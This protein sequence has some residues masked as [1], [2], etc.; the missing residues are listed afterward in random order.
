M[1]TWMDD[2]W[3]DFVDTQGIDTDAMPKD[4]LRLLKEAW[5]HG[6]RSAVAVSKEIVDDYVRESAKALER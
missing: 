3:Q 2:D 4:Q 6:A 1:S 5:L